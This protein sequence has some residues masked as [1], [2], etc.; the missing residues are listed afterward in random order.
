MASWHARARHG[1]DY[2]TW[3]DGRFFERWADPEF[4]DCLSNAYAVYSVE[5]L[6]RALRETINLF[7]RVAVDTAEMLGYHYPAEGDKYAVS[8]IEEYLALK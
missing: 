4:V 8:L 3:H 6:Q 5:D 1:L 2:D 7:R